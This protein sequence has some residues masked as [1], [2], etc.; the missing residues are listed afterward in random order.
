MSIL[1]PAATVVVG[2]TFLLGLA[3]PAVM[4]TV[5]GAVM[6]RQAGG[7]LIER[8]G[9][10]IG[11]ALIGQNF[12]AERYFHPRPSATSAADPQ[13]SSKT[14]DAPYN[15]AASAAS[16]RGPASQVL[17]DAV[18]ERMAEAGPAPVPADAVTAS[19][20]GLDP[21]ISP[22]NAARQVARVAQAR[23]IPEERVRAMVEAATSGP[24]LGILGVSRVDV[25][26]LN[27]ALDEAR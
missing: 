17:L 23:G 14:A 8:D 26:R 12:T 24:S 22:E 19:G 25:L 2:F 3:A 9:H 21:D 7:S 11:S 15:A 20:S 5:A 18:K 16:Q 27:L 6:P 13:D 4:T 1:R 10:V